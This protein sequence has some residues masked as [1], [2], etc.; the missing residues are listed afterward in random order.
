MIRLFVNESPDILSFIKTYPSD[1]EE[2]LSLK[3]S[4]YTPKRF[5]WIH[6]QK[7]IGLTSTNLSNIHFKG[8]GNLRTMSTSSSVL[9]P[10]LIYTNPDEH[11][12]LI[13]KQNKGKSGVYRWV[14][15]DSGKSYV[16][17]STMLNDRFR[18]YF[19]HS[20]LSSSKRGA[21]LICKA[22]LKYGYGEFRLEIL[23]YCPISIVL[24]REQFY[25]DK[26]NPEYNI[27]KIAGS[28]LGYKHSEASLKLMSDASKSLN[29]SEKFLE[30][31][32]EVML[33]RKLSE[34]H[35]EKMAKNNPFRVSIILSNL[36][37]G[38]NKEFTSMI[39]AALFL[40]VHMTTVKRYLV[41][42]K[43]YKGYMITKATSNLDSYSVSNLT[44][45]KQ[46]VEL[47]NNVTGITKQ[48]ST[49]KAAYQFLDI[50]PKRLLNY[51]NNKSSST[52]GQVSTIKGYIIS[53]IDSDSVK[54]NCKTI[55]VTN[56]HTNEVIN[57]SSISSA[58]EAL[59][60]PQAS[61]S[62]YL[63]RKRTTSFRGIYLFK[64]V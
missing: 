53:K 44:N 23:E 4:I 16:G 51:L 59:G 41:N 9:E 36:E 5:H 48:F 18:R 38:E 45:S 50:S 26:L 64:L 30:F 63:S 19:N 32:R 20:Y 25:I 31:K 12:G 49:M 42:N 62:V 35:L 52:N 39:Q 61:I 57:Y 13:T 17:S 11:K 8:E 37:T 28:N 55:E 56:I 58:G 3:T 43:P 54:Q 40:G 34:D 29:E 7:R 33:G 6:S 24:D 47:T 27:L 60:I 46:A 15:K 1:M 10:V 22:L 21:S 2:K 14:H